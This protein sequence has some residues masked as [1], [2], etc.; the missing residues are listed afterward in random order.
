MI[1]Q[2]LRDFIMAHPNCTKA[3]LMAAFTLNADGI[4]A[5]LAVWVKKGK[6]Q[7]S[8]SKK[9]NEKQVRYRWVENQNLA[10]RLIG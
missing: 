4:D 9:T 1:L 5:M 10:I 3:Q 2:A 6:I 8:I 7:I